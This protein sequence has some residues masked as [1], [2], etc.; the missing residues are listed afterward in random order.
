VCG[1]LCPRG[2]FFDR[3]VARISPH[4]PVPDFLRNS[5]FRWSLVVLLMGLMIFRIA[6]NP[7]DPLHW[8]RVFWMM[9]VVTTAIGL[10]LAVVVHPRSWCSICPMGTMQN[11]IGGDKNQLQ[12]DG[13]ACRSCGLC[14]RACPM[15]L[16]IVKYKD[17]GVVAERD[18]LHCSECIAACPKSVLHFDTTD[19]VA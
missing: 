6:R 12:I 7:G 14:E 2:S 8:G 3:M 15:N 17:Q 5:R 4:R 16:P 1:N 13:E 9:C 19:L 18:C 11:A 10:V